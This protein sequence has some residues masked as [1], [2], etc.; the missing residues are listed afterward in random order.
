MLAGVLPFLGN[1]LSEIFDGHRSGAVPPLPVSLMRYQP[2]INRLLEKNPKDR[3]PSAAQ[4]L[5]AFDGVGAAKPKRA[6]AP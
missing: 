1:T 3:F 6:A 5:E 2:L 4:F